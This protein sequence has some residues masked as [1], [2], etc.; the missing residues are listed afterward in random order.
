MRATVAPREEVC[1]EEDDDCDGVDEDDPEAGFACLL[2]E[3]AGCAAGRTACVGGAGLRAGAPGA[4]QCN[5][6]G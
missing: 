5:G 1:N 4:E 2:D 3:G 6:R